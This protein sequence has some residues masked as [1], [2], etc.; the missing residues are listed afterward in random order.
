MFSAKGSWKFRGEEL[1]ILPWNMGLVLTEV[2]VLDVR[3]EAWGYGLNC[4]PQSPT[5]VEGQTLSTLECGPLWKWGGC[6]CN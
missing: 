3:A 2:A 6:R 5:Q 4:D 1:E